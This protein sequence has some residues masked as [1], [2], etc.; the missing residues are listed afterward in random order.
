MFNLLPRDTVFYDLFEGMAGHAVQAS[1]NVQ[2]L[3]QNFPDVA[4]SIQR[5]REEE[6]AA[7]QLAHQALERLDRTFITPFDREDIHTLIGEL[8]DITDGVDALAK[9]FPL[10]H[11]KRMEEDFVKQTGVLIRAATTVQD[12]VSRLRKSRKLSDLSDALIEIH[13]QESLGD[14]IHHAALSRLFE[15]NVEP[16]EVLKWKELYDLI[17]DAIDGCEDVGNT[18]ERIVLKNG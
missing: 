8:D 11:V 12:A 18:L 9:R 1:R 3:A 4:A 7:D 15:G 6:H 13:H 16:L 10:F 2:Q 17:E 5:I 14:D